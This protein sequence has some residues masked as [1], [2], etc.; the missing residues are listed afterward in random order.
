MGRKTDMGKLINIL[1]YGLIFS[2]LFQLNLRANGPDGS[3]IQLAKSG[4]EK[5]MIE[6]I[7]S[8]NIN[9]S[10]LNINYQDNEGR[11]AL[12][13]AAENGHS[14]VL[15]I[16]LNLPGINVNIKDDA[17]ET[18]LM[19]TQQ[20]N[21]TSSFNLLMNHGADINA[22][23]NEGRTLLMLS[24]ANRNIKFT[25]LAI[26]NLA[27]LNVQ[28]Q[29]GN[30]ALILSVS[31]NYFKTTEILINA[32]AD[33][34]IQN[35]HGD[36][37]LIISMDSSIDDELAKLLLNFGANC[38]IQNNKEENA[39]LKARQNGKKIVGAQIL[40]E[41]AKNRVLQ[42]NYDAI[43]I[44]LFTQ[45]LKFNIPEFN[46]LA[47]FNLGY[48]EYQ[49]DFYS[50]KAF[51]HFSLVNAEHLPTSEKYTLYN[52]LGSMHYD[53]KSENI[54]NN[55]LA[56]EYFNK[57][58]QYNGNEIN[59]DKIK[60]HFYLGKIF[61]EGG[62]D[63]VRDPKTAIDHLK[64]VSEQNDNLHYK[65]LAQVELGIIYL[66]IIN[67]YQKAEQY[68]KLA[69]AQTYSE[70][71]L[72]IA[73]FYLFKMYCTVLYNN[74]KYSKA[75]ECF[76]KRMNTKC[77]L[78]EEEEIEEKYLAGR[79]FFSRHDFKNTIICLKPI[80]NKCHSYTMNSNIFAYLTISY[81]YTKEYGD[82]K[83]YLEQL[84]KEDIILETTLTLYVH[85]ILAI[86]HLKGN[87]YKQDT[88]FANEW[89]EKLKNIKCANENEIKLKKMLSQDFVVQFLNLTKY[90]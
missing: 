70:Q 12:H 53:S 14:R 62:D 33:L 18:P 52:F 50:E 36:T 63:I 39:L 89:F 37:A 72:S 41:I 4:D 61:K 31:F 56:F 54:K 35:N 90:E 10:A 78:N 79:I 87:Q 51:R 7:E 11:T 40:F 71:A 13:W 17:G 77:W 86:M 20:H 58:L 25:N 43:T 80:V 42:K 22:T 15:Q 8:N 27:D 26:K 65:A 44:S 38:F 75:I 73:N 29:Y 48:I 57:I 84:L 82:C 66:E 59:H 2:G 81:Y 23:D 47:N 69:S 19:L 1:Y 24:A 30:T 16:L 67:D 88:K 74:D 83:L 64:Q 6:L 5:A 28:D 85:Y 34:N 32:G 3:L 60:A 55:A 49:R 21:Y 76:N 45:I 68:F 9:N 46:S